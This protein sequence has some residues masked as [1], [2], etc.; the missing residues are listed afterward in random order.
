MN[1]LLITTDEQRFDTLG[2]NGNP[3]IRT[4][5]L[6]RLAAE[7]VNFQNHST[8]CAVCT[9]ARAS[10]LTGRYM[11]THGAWHA[12]VTLDPAQEGVA[13][14]LAARG[15][16]TGLFGKAH[17][18]GELT[19][20]VER[21]SPDEPY[22]GFQNVQITEDNVIGPYLDW[23]RSNYPGH[24]RDAM[25]LHN[26]YDR[27]DGFPPLAAARE[28][29]LAACYTSALPEQLHPTAWIADRTIGFMQKCREQG[30]SFFAWCSFVDPHHPWNPPE[31]F[32]SMYRE[33]DMPLPV[34]KEGENAGRGHTYSHIDGMS[35][36][37]YRQMCA[38][39]YA[40]ISHIDHHVGRMLDAMDGSGLLDDTLIVFTSDHG[41]YNGD[42]GL[43]RK[44]G[45]IERAGELYENLLHVPLIVR[46]PGGVKGGAT[47][48][49]LTQH[50]DIAPTIL[51]AA[52]L[53][54]ERSQLPGHSL[55]P[56]LRGEPTGRKYS[57]YDQGVNGSTRN[58][59]GIRDER[60]KLVHYP[61]Y[62]YVLGDLKADPHEYD[63]VLDSES[64]RSKRQ[65]LSEEL[66]DWLLR[67]PC[68][69]L[70]KE[71]IW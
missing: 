5:R 39:Y 61:G 42:H 28:G 12:G 69:R 34:M 38:A 64:H 41:D 56:A 1:I 8:S 29:R 58:I 16:R 65:E 53:E 15:Y 33:S 13:H 3:V 50:E 27:P 26:E 10:L 68:H 48:R 46:P 43:I 52:G 70:P 51:E 62:G 9:P 31:P 36:G 60:Y 23:I 7:G 4:P 25:H 37:E 71:V 24:V 45:A 59:I 66:L 2:C 54:L 63:N 55:S 11:R 32:A 14:R 21:L 57:Y 22:Y 17:F 30:E 47:F 40:M 44:V 35:P 20:Y 19:G 49:G 6:D 67:T 18:E